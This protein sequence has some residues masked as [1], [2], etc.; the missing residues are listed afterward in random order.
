MSL[1]SKVE[2]L[3]RE[4]AAEII[5]PRFQKLASGEIEEKMPGE[6]VTV[7]DREFEARLDPALR[8]LLPGSVVVGEEACAADE[9]LRSVSA[10]MGRC[11]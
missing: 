5:M 8:E 3:L 2:G 9:R 10:A 4:V 11:G 7:A 1:T 6:L